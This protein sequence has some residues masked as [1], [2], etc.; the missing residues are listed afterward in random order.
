MILKLPNA[1]FYSLLANT[2]IFVV[3]TLFLYS[4]ESGVFEYN[5]LGV[6]IFIFMFSILALL[7]VILIIS[8]LLGFIFFKKNPHLDSDKCVNNKRLDTA[9]FAIA[10]I[11]VFLLIY[12]HDKA[13][14]AEK[15]TTLILMGIS[16]TV[17]YALSYLFVFN[18]LCY[19][20][21]RYRRE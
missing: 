10:A 19:L 4:K 15:L 3:L 20:C 17:Y 1:V 21:K 5:Y 7:T 11:F 16:T 9:S 6:S 8:L 12:I 14:A 18:L 2:Q 13:L